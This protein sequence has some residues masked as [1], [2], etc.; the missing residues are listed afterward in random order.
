MI[1]TTINTESTT[2]LNKPF[3][4]KKLLETAK[5]RLVFQKYGQKRSIPRNQGRYV[6]FR[7]YDPFGADADA[8]TLTEGVTPNGQ[9]L[10]QSRVVATVKQYG[11]YVEVSD[12]LDMTGYDEVLGDSAELLGE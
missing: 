11:A 4:D 12:L 5:T 8:L 9:E 1:N 10:S 3:Y 6:E 2:F 7:K